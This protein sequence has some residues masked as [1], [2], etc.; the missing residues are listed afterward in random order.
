MPRTSTL[1]AELLAAVRREVVRLCGVDLRNLP[2]DRSVAGAIRAAVRDAQQGIVVAELDQLLGRSLDGAE[3]KAAHWA[4]ERL[5]TSGRLR[6]LRRG[7]DGL[8]LTHLQLV[9]AAG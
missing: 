3:R 5:E 7:Y 4:L 8:R 9:E 6:R 1:D 2:S